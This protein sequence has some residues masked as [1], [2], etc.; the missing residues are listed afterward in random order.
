MRTDYPG[1]DRAYQRKRK[2]PDY[3]GWMTHDALAEDWRLSWQPFI[4]T[5]SFPNQGRLLELGCGAGNLSLYFAQQGYE[6]VGVDIAPTAIAWARDNATH[7]GISATFIEGNVLK[8][9][10]IADASFDI[11]LDGR[12]FHCIIGSD[13]AQ[14]LHTAHRVLKP[15]GTLAINTMCNEVPATD[16]WRD[17]FDP[18]SRCTLHDDLATRYVG[19]S[20]DILQEIIHAGFRL[21]HVEV[22]PVN[23]EDDVPALQIIAQ[24]L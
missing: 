15:S 18:Q 7:S 21:L 12:C 23:D 14:F 11:V 22:L 20:N 8:L 6:V 9:A 16:Y 3:A 5:Q 13:R 24:K 4:Q 1:H 17:H 19:D 2:N 10:E